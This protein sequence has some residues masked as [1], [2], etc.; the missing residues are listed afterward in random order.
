MQ[1]LDEAA[2]QEQ[3]AVLHTLVTNCAA[4]MQRLDEAAR[5][6]QAAVLHTLQ[7]ELRQARTC[8]LDDSCLS[9]AMPGGQHEKSVH[10]TCWAAG[11]LALRLHLGCPGPRH[12]CMLS[13]WCALCDANLTNARSSTWTMAEGVMTTYRRLLQVQD[14]LAAE[15]REHAGA[16]Q[17]VQEVMLET[18][19]GSS[20]LTW[21]PVAAAGPEGH[22]QLLSPEEAAAAERKGQ[23]QQER[24]AAE[25][26]S[27]RDGL[28]TS[29]AEQAVSLAQKQQQVDSLVRES[30]AAKQQ[31]AELQA[32]QHQLQAGHA[33]Q[34]GQVHS[35][36]AA[37]LSALREQLV[38][39]QQEVQQLQ[40]Q[41]DSA[42]HQLELQQRDLRE[43]HASTVHQLEQQQRNLREQH[44]AELHHTEQRA[45]GSRVVRPGADHHHQQ[46]LLQQWARGLLQ[47]QQQLSQAAAHLQQLQQPHGQATALQ[48]EQHR[49][50]VTSPRQT[51]Q[52]QHATDLA[53][54]K[55]L[56]DQRAAELRLAQQEQQAR[57]LGEACQQ[58]AVCCAEHDSAQQLVRE[59]HSL[60]LAALKQGLQEQHTA[61]LSAVE[62]SLGEQHAEE[63]AQIQLLQQELQAAGLS[64]QEADAAHI[65]ELE[66]RLQQAQAAAPDP[67]LQAAAEVG[68]VLLRHLRCCCA[69]GLHLQ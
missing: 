66:E 29:L 23:S 18:P 28:E 59:Q 25:L 44:A 56:L 33:A 51:V 19:Q 31:C 35:Q 34:L 3:C 36:H 24:H 69:A 5:Q 49:G 16:M 40:E 65:R 57:L 10:R 30:L 42:M 20:M 12:C 11:I 39:T 9:L 53:A 63:L 61:E 17:W 58:L 68:T 4:C 41:H 21:R 38:T 43:Q 50:E 60:E 37:E 14:G 47:A 22:Q 26:R 46:L 27:V 7:Q 64:Q 55:Q 13:V 45:Q 6:E 2:L 15:Q 8:L 54:A 48:Q 52:E 62:A 67:A 1:R 32:A